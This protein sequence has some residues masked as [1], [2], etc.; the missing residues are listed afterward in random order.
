[1]RFRNFAFIRVRI[2][3]NFKFFYK[4]ACSLESNCSTLTPNIFA[5]GS[6]KSDFGGLPLFSQYA[7]L[8]GCVSNIFASACLDI[9]A[10]SR[11]FIKFTP[12][13]D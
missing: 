13:T 11:I 4:S 3:L 1:M 8:E 6:N 9:P 12:S 2:F 7:K 10:F 5:M